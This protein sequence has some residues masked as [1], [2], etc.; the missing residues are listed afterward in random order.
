MNFFRE[1]FIDKKY[2]QQNGIF[3]I[4]SWVGGSLKMGFFPP[5]R[6]FSLR[7][8]NT[9]IFSGSAGDLFLPCSS[10][11]NRV[12]FPRFTIINGVF[13]WHEDKSCRCPTRWRLCSLG[14]KRPI[15]QWRGA[16]PN[17]THEY[18][19]VTGGP[20]QFVTLSRGENAPRRDFWA[21]IVHHKT[22]RSR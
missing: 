5:W 11:S 20:R 13:L 6:D 19:I 7:H 8:R 12:T 18:A 14:Q 1:L 4:H 2:V 17:V 9:W 22:F 16:R 15:L 3:A 10:F 21:M